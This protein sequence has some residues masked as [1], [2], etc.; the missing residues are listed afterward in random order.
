MP[1]TFFQRVGLG[2]AVAMLVLVGCGYP[3]RGK[4][5]VENMDASIAGKMAR[6]FALLA[7]KHDVEFSSTDIEMLETQLLESYAEER[8]RGERKHPV[9]LKI[10]DGV[11]L[12]EE[13]AAGIW[14][15][16][17]LD[18]GVSPKLGMGEA[19]ETMISGLRFMSNRAGE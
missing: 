14:E 5:D 9:L 3:E 15:E 12:T 2:L 1:T 13:R 10:Y 4:S 11:L 18:W 6:G 17:F 7:L 8:E 19:I 16:W